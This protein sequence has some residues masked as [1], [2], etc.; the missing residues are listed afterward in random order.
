[1]GGNLNS[2]TIPVANRDEINKAIKNGQGKGLV[3]GVIENTQGL[4]Q[5]KDLY[6]NW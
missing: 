1:M 5:L 2:D 6:D 3:Q 4:K